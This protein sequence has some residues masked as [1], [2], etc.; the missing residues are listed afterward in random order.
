MIEILKYRKSLRQY[1]S[2]EVEKEKIEK[3]INAALLSPSS[4]NR[5]PWEFIIINDKVSLEKLSNVREVGGKFLKESPLAI[6]IIS[7]VEKCDVWIEDC[8]ITGIIMQLEAEKLGLGSC[9]VQIR[10]RFHNDTKTASNY[11]K[12]VLNIPERYEVLSIISIGYRESDNVK[13][14]EILEKEK[15]VH[16]N[17]Y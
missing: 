17:G 11:V 8:T 15:K 9:W 16:Y 14:K 4:R 1:S 7:D 2:K 12:E 10:K 13:E 5:K 3:I 6:V